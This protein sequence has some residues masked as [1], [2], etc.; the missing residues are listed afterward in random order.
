M[1]AAG[2]EPSRATRFLQPARNDFFDFLKDHP[3][4][5]ERF[6]N[7]Q[8]QIAALPS[9]EQTLIAKPLAPLTTNI[10]SP[11]ADISFLTAFKETSSYS[12]DPIILGLKAYREGR[13]AE[14]FTYATEA[15]NRSDP[16]GQLGLGL[17]YAGGIGTAKDY[18][19]AAEYLWIG[20]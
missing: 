13:F 17:F 9:R 10:T 5:A 18:S 6:K 12:D 8:T 4:D 19:K 7:I 3:S 20:F 15:A 11:S 2:F 16:R 1:Y 14:A